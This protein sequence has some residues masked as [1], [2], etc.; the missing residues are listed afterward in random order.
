[1]GLSGDWLIVLRLFSITA[2]TGSKKNLIYIKQ[3]SKTCF[4]GNSS[5]SLLPVYLCVRILRCPTYELIK[6][7]KKE[8]K[9]L[10]SLHGEIKIE[11]QIMRIWWELWSRASNP[12]ICI[13]LR[14]M[15]VRERRVVLEFVRPWEMIV[16]F[17]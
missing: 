8:K 16:L 13:C 10:M 9:R 5:H 3:N 1:M 6:V 4:L 7:K 17:F 2:K 14:C 11:R 12:L 15:K